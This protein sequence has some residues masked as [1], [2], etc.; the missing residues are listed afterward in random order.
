MGVGFRG[1]GREEGGS[2][3]GGRDEGGGGGS[4]RELI[5][6]VMP[7]TA[8]GAWIEAAAAAGGAGGVG[9]GYKGQG[10]GLLRRLE[11]G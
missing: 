9:G 3:R 11:R 7:R 1:G 2:E 6:R 8:V 5:M 4:S 10:D